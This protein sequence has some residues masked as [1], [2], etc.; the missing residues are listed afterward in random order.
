MKIVITGSTGF[1]GRH[2]LYHLKQ[3]GHQV[4]PVGRYELKQGAK[5]LASIISGSGAVINLAGAPIN[6]RWTSKYK[7][8]IVSSRLDTTR[9]LVEA[10]SLLEQPPAIFISTSAIGAF[11][12]EGEYTEADSPNATDF[13]GQLSKD[14]E[15]AALKAERFGIR[16]LIF[17]FALV[18]GHD[19]G[20]MKQLLL[21]FRLGFG[22]TVGDGSQHFSWIHID[23]LVNAY[24]LTLINHEMSGIYHLSAPNPVNN[25]TFT[26]TL[27]AVLHRP[28]LFRVPRLL[29]QIA[30]GEGAD[31]ISSGQRVTSER[32]SEAGFSFRYPELPQALQAIVHKSDS[33]CPVRRGLNSWSSS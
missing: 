21:P 20:M 12:P 6:K 2:L 3:T 19:G 26:R 18:L 24:Q 14:W 16:T 29:L 15:A 13:L 31:V 17:R 33:A 10:M 8:E 25:L 32:L 22:G 4:V 30:L 7:Q 9:L 23:D 11:A 27:G 1:I 28:T 5:S